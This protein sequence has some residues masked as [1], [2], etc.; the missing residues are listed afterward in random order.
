M[1][2]VTRQGELEAIYQTAP[3]GLCAY[4]RNLR[5][6]RIN[7][8]L[9]EIN[10]IPAEDHIGKTTR[11]ILP[12]HMAD[13]I[14]P[15]L[16]RVLSS[17]EPHLGVEVEGEIRSMPGIR[18]TWMV[19][20]VPLRNRVGSIAGVNV[21][22]EEVTAQRRLQDQ[23]AEQRHLR[24]LARQ[25]EQAREEERA[26]IARELHDELG[27]SLNAMKLQIEWVARDL[28]RPPELLRQRLAQSTNVLDESIKEVRRISHAL[29]PALLDTLGLSAAMKD[30]VNTVQAYSSL[31]FDVKEPQSE[32]DLS[33]EA[34]TALFR[35]F[36]ESLTNVCK[37]A[38]ATAVSVVLSVGNGCCVLEVSDDGSGTEQERLEKSLC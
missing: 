13:D 14:E 4:D 37:H 28:S 9:A 23:E 3:I 17:G 12:P 6:L 7:D 24:Q 2:G 10:G 36:Q 26:R 5:Y 1:G 31:R 30:L 8:R 21:S 34:A 15:H 16:R 38:R 20:Y 33:P 22:V 35:I 32:P 29:R 27:Q 11:E 19:N 25:L 18:R